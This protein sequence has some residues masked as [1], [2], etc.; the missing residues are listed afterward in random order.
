MVLDC[1]EPSKYKFKF[2]LKFG[3]YFHN[4]KKNIRICLINP[5]LKLKS[6]IK[7]FIRLIIYYLYSMKTH[8]GNKR[9]RNIINCL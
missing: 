6:I 1:L 7:I 4:I 5:I 3:L 9:K 8:N 2:L